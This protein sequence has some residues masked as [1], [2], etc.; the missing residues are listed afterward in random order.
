MAELF[1][2]GIGNGICAECSLTKKGVGFKIAGGREFLCWEHFRLLQEA[3]KP[4]SPVALELPYVLPHCGCSHRSYR[5]CCRCRWNW[6]DSVCRSESTTTG[7]SE[8]EGVARSHSS[9]SSC[10]TTRTR[11]NSESH[12]G[13]LE[14]A[15]ML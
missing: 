10:G 6:S 13:W 4:R 2:T 3:L 8:N 7:R 15:A 5:C 1:I 14:D 12:S 9:H 11:V